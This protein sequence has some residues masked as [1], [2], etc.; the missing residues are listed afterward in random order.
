MRAGEP[1]RGAVSACGGRAAQSL[2]PWPLPML[3]PLQLLLSLPRACPGLQDPSL[4]IPRAV[5]ATLLA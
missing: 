3:F 4:G 5:S 2:T 1:R